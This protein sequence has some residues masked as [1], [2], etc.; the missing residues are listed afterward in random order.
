MLTGPGAAKALAYQIQHAASKVS[1]RLCTKMSNARKTGVSS[2]DMSEAMVPFLNEIEELRELPDSTVI[3][4][5]LV[6]I[7]GGYSYSGL[8]CGGSGYGER[9]SD[10][11][12]DDLLVELATERRNIEPAW[13]FLRVLETLKERASE[14][15]DYGIENFC[16]QTINLLSAWERDL[17]VKEKRSLQDSAHNS[18]S[19]DLNFPTGINSYEDGCSTSEGDDYWI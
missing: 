2:D 7:L 4:F 17:P 13:N 19:T 16:V 11:D 15:Y 12:V 14:L 10:P 8:D 18:N 6:M 9:P 5:D 1:D 3:A